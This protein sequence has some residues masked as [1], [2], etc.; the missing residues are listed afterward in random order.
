MGRSWP[1]H[2]T[3]DLRLW[4]PGT[5][6]RTSSTRWGECSIPGTKALGSG[7]LTGTVPGHGRTV[8]VPASAL[9]SEPPDES[10]MLPEP[11]VAGVLA[12]VLLLLL[13][14]NAWDLR[15]L[16]HDHGAMGAAGALPALGSA[17]LGA[18]V[19]MTIA[20]PL[21]YLAGRLDSLTGSVLQLRFPGD[22]VVQLAGAALLAA[23][24]VLAFWS[25]HALK[26]GTLT[27][28]GPYARMRHPM[29]AGYVLAFAGLFPLTLNLLALLSL[30][31][32]PAQIAVALREEATLETRYGAAYRAYAARTGRFLPWA[33]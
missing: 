21:L 9:S 18:F 17:G 20:Y 23:G 24:L 32:I 31:A 15:K 19:L 7:C 28:T 10:V 29:Y 1:V 5:S 14:R 2:Q 11:V 30:L 25:L 22:T 16:P 3:P 8:P 27:T 12:L 33:R 6:S 4:R 13:I 26:P